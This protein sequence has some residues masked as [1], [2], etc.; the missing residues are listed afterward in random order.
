MDRV[1]GLEQLHFLQSEVLLEMIWNSAYNMLSQGAILPLISSFLSHIPFPSSAWK[2]SWRFDRFYLIISS[3]YMEDCWAP[4]SE[5]TTIPEFLNICLPSYLLQC[6]TLDISFLPPP[7]CVCDATT[8]NSSKNLPLLWRIK[9]G[10]YF[11]STHTQRQR[12]IASQGFLLPCGVLRVY[13]LKPVS[14]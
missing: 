12:N 2:V 9:K 14:H 6:W 13:S 5:V 10:L 3:F 1:A 4:Y 8:N 7:P 11:A